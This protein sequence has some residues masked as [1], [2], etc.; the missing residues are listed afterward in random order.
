MAERARARKGEDEDPGQAAPAPIQ[1]RRRRLR[2]GRPGAGSATSGRLVIIGN[3]MV[4]RRLC[5]TLLQTAGD[6][7]LPEM[8][9]FGEE[10]RPAYD[11]VHL[12]DVL[13]GRAPDSLL[14][15]PPSW[16]QASG[17]QLHLGDQVEHIDRQAQ[18]LISRRGQ[19]LRYDRLVHLPAGDR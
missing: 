1:L 9:V 17:I 2:Q 12:G 4:S 15:A 16:Y 10:T 19:R 7:T 6:E 8:V 5:E 14:L 3:G 13:R 11:R 18:L